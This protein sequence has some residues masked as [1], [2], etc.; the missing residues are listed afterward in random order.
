M[1][2]LL[3]CVR[4]RPRWVQPF[5]A[6]AIHG[7]AAGGTAAAGGTVRAGEGVSVTIP[8]VVLMD[9]CGAGPT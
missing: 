5:L 4:Y 7:T 1:L 3:L 9:V 2:C 8:E 6:H